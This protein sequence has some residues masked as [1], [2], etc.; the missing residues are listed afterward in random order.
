MHWYGIIE[1][2]GIRDLR[3]LHAIIGDDIPESLIQ[4]QAIRIIVRLL[5]RYLYLPERKDYIG[6]AEAARRMMRHLTSEEI[7]RLG[8][9]SV[10]GFFETFRD[11]PALVIN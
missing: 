4:K 9:G 11:I 5:R 7:M 8:G 10:I 2:L 1:F 6:G 3:C